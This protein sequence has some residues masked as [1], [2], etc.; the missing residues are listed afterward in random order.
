MGGEDMELERMECSECGS[1]IFQI[2]NQAKNELS[3]CLQCNSTK[4]SKSSQ[5]SELIESKENAYLK[6]QSANMDGRRYAMLG[7]W[8]TVYISTYFTLLS[9]DDV[10]STRMN[11]VYASISALFGL[12]I[13]ALFRNRKSRMALFNYF[14]WA[15]GERKTDAKAMVVPIV[16]AIVLIITILEYII[17]DP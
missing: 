9:Q 3:P 17:L 6:N 13:L 10:S 7:I 15:L 12:M 1:V 14:D 16:F 2:P 4:R 8:I 5:S 11:M